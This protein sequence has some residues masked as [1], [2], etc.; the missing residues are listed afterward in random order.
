MLWRVA[1]GTELRS[2]SNY[3]A[4]YDV[5]FGADGRWVTSA[6]SEEIWT[7]RLS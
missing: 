7:W 3:G 5:V 2:L 1:D 4:S 6:S